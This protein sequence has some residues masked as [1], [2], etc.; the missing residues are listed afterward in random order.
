MNCLNMAYSSDY[1][2]PTYASTSHSKLAN[3][4]PKSG[5]WDHVVSTGTGMFMITS[6]ISF[7]IWDNTANAHI[8]TSDINGNTIGVDKF[9][10]SFVIFL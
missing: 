6:P 10:D 3:Y 9:A 8:R 4:S 1:F 7:G 2:A 5:I